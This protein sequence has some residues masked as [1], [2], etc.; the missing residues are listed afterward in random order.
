[1]K[2]LALLLILS[3]FIVEVPVFGVCKINQIKNCQPVKKQKKY[4]PN[5]INDSKTFKKL[6][7]TNLLN[8]EEDV[9]YSA[10]C[11]FGVCSPKPPKR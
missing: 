2:R 8:S 7:E 10:S 11:E 1:M 6:P 9:Y 3:L 5:K 4:E